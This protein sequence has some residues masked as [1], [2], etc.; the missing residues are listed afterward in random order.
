MAISRYGPGGL[1]YPDDIPDRIR[2]DVTILD[3]ET[4]E[5]IHSGDT[6]FADTTYWFWSDG[7][8]SCD[9]NRELAFKDG[10]ESEPGV[11]LGA[12]RYLIIEIDMG[13]LDYLNQYYPQELVDRFL[14][15]DNNGDA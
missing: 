3:T 2:V 9:C 13:D 10:R 7:N 4:G 14:K 5:T 11:C 12:N 8:G 6:R 1:A 15:D